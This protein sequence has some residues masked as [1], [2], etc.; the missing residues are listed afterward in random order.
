MHSPGLTKVQS[1]AVTLDVSSYEPRSTIR[2]AGRH[3]A[4]GSRPGKHGGLD[5]LTRRWT[6]IGA[7]IV[8]VA[9]VLVVVILMTMHGGSGSQGG[10]G[11]GY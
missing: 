5:V 6:V 10:G 8:A 3:G 4:E 7:A 1:D 9:I 11:G 2:V